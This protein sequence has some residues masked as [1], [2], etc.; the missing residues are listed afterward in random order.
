M[1]LAFT[2]RIRKLFDR[3]AVRITI[4]AIF[5]LLMH[6][7]ILSLQVGLPGL[8]LPG[9]GLPWSEQRAQTPELSIRIANVANSPPVDQQVSPA[10]IPNELGSK[11]LE[12]IA[13][14]DQILTELPNAHVKQAPSRIAPVAPRS[15]KALTSSPAIA[16]AKRK[17]GSP[18][19]DD[20]S[21]PAAARSQ[22]ELI[23]LNG[24]RPGSFSV[25]AP[26][27][28][29]WWRAAPKVDSIP[30]PIQPLEEAAPPTIAVQSSKQTIERAQEP[31]PALQKPSELESFE[32][33]DEMTAKE[34]EPS[35][36]P[37]VAAELAVHKEGEE[38]AAQDTVRKLEEQEAAQ[39]AQDNQTRKLEEAR[40]E[41]KAEAEAAR[42]VAAKKLEEQQLA[43]REQEAAEKKREDEKQQKEQD[44]ER[45]AKE[46]AARKLAEEIA[47]QKAAALALQKQRE[48]EQLEGIKRQE[49]AKEKQQA[50]E[51][52]ARQQAEEIA[53]QKAAEIEKQR[54][55][56]QV[57][58]LKKAQALAAAQKA[59]AEAEALAASQR[60]SARA[61]AAAAAT[62]NAAG[63][64][65]ASTQGT[66]GT[67][68]VGNI[69]NQ[70]RG[71]G[72]LVSRALE[73][74][75]KIDLT[76]IAPARPNDPDHPE[77]DS[78]RHSIFGIVDHDIVVDAYI[79][80]WR[81]KIERNGN[82]NYSQSSKDLAR[83]NPVVTV[84]IRSDGSV[85]DI[86]FNRTSGRRDIDEAVMRIVRVNA[87]YGKFPENLARKYPVIEI[88]RVWSF[89]ETLRILEEVH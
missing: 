59:E 67:S 39:Q 23:A 80:G 87:P 66:A 53:R 57:A 12:A 82:L 30:L 71:T 11:P 86:I 15:A 20:Q 43:Q 41:A 5:S 55:E 9:L 52:A 6:G 21:T 14:S 78:R 48:L 34:P 69:G 74:A 79:R 17:N 88:R 16:A 49:L 37:E 13:A 45:L 26:D 47:F 56:E 84:A 38:I 3:Y 4:G 24:D 64:S 58:A 29:S 63:N 27:Q 70:S 1:K 40:K 85:E 65:G 68:S 31:A 33:P 73:Q 81:N 35:K 46:V 83:E 18:P 2:A 25:P 62:A 36:T 10:P 54:Q 50:A 75:G 42:Q 89:D 19:P 8:G 76:R 44:A 60:E 7:L 32:R 61:A 77:E 51:L 22:P 28:D 72:D